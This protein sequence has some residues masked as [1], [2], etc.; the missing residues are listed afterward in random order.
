MLAFN[1]LNRTADALSQSIAGLDYVDVDNSIAPTSARING[2]HLRVAELNAERGRYWCDFA[3]QI[4]RTPT[5]AA[6]DVWLLNEFDLGMARSDQA[7]TVRLLAYALGFNY[8]WS[9]EFIELT[10]GNREEQR[11][12]KGK[13]NKYGLHGNAIL[14]RWPIEEAHVV[15]HKSS[16]ALFTSKGRDTAGGAEKRLG[17]RMTLFASTRIPFDGG[18]GATEDVTLGAT[19]AQTS[20]QHDKAHTCASTADMR[21][22]VE[23]LGHG[24]ALIGGDTWASTCHWLKLTPLVSKR[25][26]F[27]TFNKKKQKVTISSNAYMDDYVCAKGFRRVGDVMRLPCVGRGEKSQFVL[28]DHI[29]VV[30]DVATVEAGGREESAAMP[31]VHE[32]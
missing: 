17:G 29:Y 15:R 26:G 19:H 4:R 1:P 2:S 10:N 31:A 22:A 9:T 3:I 7:H 27:N 21:A 14:S 24:K 13:D 5:L 25:S 8:A 11:R 6:V 12:T 28:S 18:G 30:V 20:W 23:R 16:A 32:C